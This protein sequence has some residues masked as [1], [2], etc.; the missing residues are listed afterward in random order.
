M[1]I[2]QRDIAALR[3]EQFRTFELLARAI[4]HRIAPGFKRAFVVWFPE[5]ASAVLL[6]MS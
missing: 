3:V 4:E 1:R 5:C 2:S 6:G